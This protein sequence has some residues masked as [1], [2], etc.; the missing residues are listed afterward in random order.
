[1]RY[2]SNWCRFCNLCGQVGIRSVTAAQGFSRTN[3]LNGLG[4][5][6]FD[7]NKSTNWFRA[8]LPVSVSGDI[9]QVDLTVA[10]VEDEKFQSTIIVDFVAEVSQSICIYANVADGVGS[11]AYASGHAALLVANDTVVGSPAKVT[12]YGLWPDAYANATFSNGAASDVR[13]NFAL[14][15]RTQFP[16]IYCEMVTDRELSE[17]LLEVSKPTTFSCTN[18]AAAY[19]AN[20]FLLGTGTFVNATDLNGLQTARKVGQSI[21]ALNGGSNAPLGGLPWATRRLLRAQPAAGRRTLF[22][23]S[24][25]TCVL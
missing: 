25:D 3:T 11:P 14:D 4:K 24:S 22:V 2:L 18:N 9:V 1:L 13:V 17:F 21:R 12:T 5:L 23:N 7:A 10:N 8:L 16:Y 15:D 20:L 6:A 19:A